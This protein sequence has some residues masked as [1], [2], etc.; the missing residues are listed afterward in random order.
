[1][2]KRGGNGDKPCGEWFFKETI[3]KKKPSSNPRKMRFHQKG[4]S[5]QEGE[6]AGCRREK[7]GFE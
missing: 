3:R 7:S 1:V 2:R 6:K 4:V 5:L